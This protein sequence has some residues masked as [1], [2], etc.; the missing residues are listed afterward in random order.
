MTTSQ[1]LER[2]KE[3]VERDEEIEVKR[4]GVTEDGPV[5]AEDML[6]NEARVSKETTLNSG[7]PNPLDSEISIGEN[8]NVDSVVAE[9]E[10]RQ[11]EP[12]NKKD[13]EGKSNVEPETAACEEGQSSPVIAE[14]MAK[15]IDK[16]GEDVENAG[17]S[18]DIGQELSMESENVRVGLDNVG[19][20]LDDIVRKVVSNIAEGES[21]KDIVEG[22][23]EKES[24]ETQEKQRETEKENVET[25]GEQGSL[26][27]TEVV[28]EGPG[29]EGECLDIVPLS[30]IAIPW[31]GS[32]K[33]ELGS[34]KPSEKGN[35]TKS[36]HVAKKKTSSQQS[37]NRPLSD[38]ELEHNLTLLFSQLR[39]DEEVVTVPE[40]QEKEEEQDP[41]KRK[42]SKRKEKSVVE[43]EKTKVSEVEIKKDATEVN[44][45]KKASKSLKKRMSN[46][47]EEA[48]SSKRIK[49][50]VSMGPSSSKQRKLRKDEEKLR[51]ENLR[52]QKVLLGRV[53]DPEEVADFMVNLQY[54]DDHTLVCKVGKVDFTMDETQLGEF[55]NIPTEGVKK[56]GNDKYIKASDDFK[57]LIVRIGEQ[58]TTETLYKK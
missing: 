8:V 4:K 32:S 24:I 26:G 18:D 29:L 47:T 49:V 19:E 39:D 45:G 35:T 43:K 13:I 22:E 20:N 16:L 3:I 6:K 14:K 53:F 23:N 15:N 44:K 37:K 50:N 9:C 11:S 54:T 57:S 21:G 1:Y 46:E 30:T 42:N 38:P 17:V 5:V 55:L 58:V 40:T 12:L 36:K 27:K 10:E 34:S 48:G 28:N 2:T 56:L 7:N 31:E 52:G 41:L 33:M 25:Q 51:H